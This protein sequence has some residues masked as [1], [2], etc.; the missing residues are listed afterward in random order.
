[1]PQVVARKVK[2][3][4]VPILPPHDP[5]NPRPKVPAMSNAQVKQPV[6]EIPKVKN[7][8][9]EADSD[10]EEEEEIS[11]ETIVKQK[12]SPKKVAMFIQECINQ[13]MKEDDS[14][15]SETDM[16]DSEY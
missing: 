2:A 12:P 6:K 10:S 3:E 15:Q 5:M 14:D 11:F 8:Q 16:N 1:M 7:V 4:T 9:L 13:I